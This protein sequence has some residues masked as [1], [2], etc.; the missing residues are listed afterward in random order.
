MLTEIIHP[1]VLSSRTQID[2]DLTEMREQLRKQVNRLRELRLKKNQ[3][4]GLPISPN[5][6]SKFGL[7]ENVHRIILW[8]R[9]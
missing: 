4:P 7:K 5:S 8:H 2:E 9:R 6:Q 1:G 3:E